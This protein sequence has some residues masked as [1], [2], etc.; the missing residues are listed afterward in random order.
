MLNKLSVAN[1][2]KPTTLCFITFKF[3]HIIFR[4]SAKKI[5][6]SC[7]CIIFVKEK[8]LFYIGHLF[9]KLIAADSGKRLF[10]ALLIFYVIKHNGVYSAI[11]IHI[12]GKQLHWFCRS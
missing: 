5:V 11:A 7:V 1:V 2:L 10:F 12:R 6:I 8:F 9:G 3:Q 4:C